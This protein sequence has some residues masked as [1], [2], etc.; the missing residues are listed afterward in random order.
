MQSS[1]PWILET[2]FAFSSWSS[3]ALAIPRITVFLQTRFSVFYLR[4]PWARRWGQCLAVHCFAL[5]ALGGQAPFL[6]PSYPTFSMFTTGLDMCLSP[7][8]P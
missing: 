2:P 7:P 8:L 5:W 4:V 3:G 1:P 6:T